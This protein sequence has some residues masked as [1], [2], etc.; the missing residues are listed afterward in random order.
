MIGLVVNG[1][2]TI[3]FGVTSPGI[4]PDSSYD[5]VMNGDTLIGLK[6]VDPATYESVIQFMVPAILSIH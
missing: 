6:G 5:Y 1:Q 4:F 2:C 3:D